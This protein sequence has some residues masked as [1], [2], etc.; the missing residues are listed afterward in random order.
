MI[1]ALGWMC[2]GLVAGLV[3][4]AIMPRKDPGKVIGTTA[5]GMV[6]G[7]IG[8]ISDDRWACTMR[9]ILLDSSWRLLGR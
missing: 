2:F 8:A 6:G 7:V 5:L 1:T 3:A 9:L 4:K